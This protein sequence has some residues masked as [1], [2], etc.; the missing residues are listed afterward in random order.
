[1]FF[2]TLCV[3]LWQTVTTLRYP[4]EIAETPLV[5]CE[6]ERIIIKIHTT[7]SNPSHIYAD[8]FA[9]DPQCSSRN[10]NKVSLKHGMCGMST[11]ETIAILS[12]E[13]PSGVIQRVCIS[14][15]L[16]PLFVTDADRSYCAQCVYIKSHVVGDFESSLDISDS[17]PTELPPQLDLSAMP[18][19]SYTIHKGSE[20]GPEVHYAVVGES[21][22]HVWQCLG[23]NTGILVQNCF[24][25]DGQGHRILII[26]QNGSSLLRCGVDQYVMATP[27]YSPD[28]TSA[29]QE[30]RVFKFAQR[31]VI[32][33]ICQIRICLRSDECG[34]LS[35][36]STC[37][38]LQ[39]RL[40]NA[41]ALRDQPVDGT[42]RILK[43]EE[44]SPFSIDEHVSTKKISPPSSKPEDVIK[45]NSTVGSIYF[46]YD[47][48][49]HRR[50]L[51]Q[52]HFST[53]NGYPEID[54]VGE[55]KV[56]DTVED[57]MYFE[58]SKDS[59]GCISL[60]NCSFIAAVLLIAPVLLASAFF[61]STG[62]SSSAKNK[63]IRFEN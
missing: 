28:L 46:G 30:T 58:R 25:E 55:L 40:E 37:S 39:E 35:P 62:R 48:S 34:K 16:H 33:F 11:E 12:Q 14:V 19:C 2:I 21:V 60:L 5:L 18:K 44:P 3:I 36:P 41:K 54:L 59:G 45:Q 27:E 42:K 43:L 10:M 63:I 1:M 31:T 32:R 9:D 52:Q 29:F 49:R 6:P 4:N 53:S 24:V 22:Y 17:L 8:N 56:L 50:E 51:S 23:E 57:V 61:L 13:N 7:S 26:D 47:P 20:S 15:Q 38:T